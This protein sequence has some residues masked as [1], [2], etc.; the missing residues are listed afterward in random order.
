MQV[1]QI[2][3]NS[4]PRGLVPLEEIFDQDD[5]ARNP[6]MSPT[7]VGVGD[8]NLGTSKKPKMV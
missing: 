7:E 1:L 6:T 4:I 5:V 2:K 3:D 8:L